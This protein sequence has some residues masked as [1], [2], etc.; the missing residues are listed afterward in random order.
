[1]SPGTKSEQRLE[2]L[3]H[4]DQIVIFSTSCVLCMQ[5]NETSETSY[6]TTF[7]AVFILRA[8]SD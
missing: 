3:L 6:V 8:F 5:I 1:M 2:N 4:T 7:S